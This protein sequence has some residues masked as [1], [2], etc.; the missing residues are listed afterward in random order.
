MLRRDIG[1]ADLP[2]TRLD[3]QGRH[4]ART[5]RG[6]P[7]PPRD[8]A[9]RATIFARWC[10]C[11]TLESCGALRTR[12][13]HDRPPRREYELNDAVCGPG[14]L[15]SWNLVHLSGLLP[16]IRARR[17]PGEHSAR[18]TGARGGEQRQPPASPRPGSG[19]RPPERV[20]KWSRRT[21]LQEAALTRCLSA[22]RRGP[23]QAAAGRR[24]SS[25]SRR[26]LPRADAACPE[27]TRS[28]ASRHGLVQTGA[29]RH[30]LPRADTVCR[31]PTRPGAD[32]RKP[33]RSAPSRR[34]LARADAAWREPTRPGAS[35]HGLPRAD[36][37]CREP[38]RPAASRHGLPRAD[39]ACRELSLSRRRRNARRRTGLEAGPPSLIVSG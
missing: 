14:N 22:G 21:S 11:W 24:G 23:P 15:V 28:A 35:R 27:P 3:E 29:S 16:A 19:P 6:P 32:R 2:H 33:T 37:A 26:G 1:L 25:A 34:G 5:P 10:R 17:P 39:T 20:Y 8:A 4:S 31:E 18:H 30:G 12:A 36:T 7:A 9:F 13:L 38:T